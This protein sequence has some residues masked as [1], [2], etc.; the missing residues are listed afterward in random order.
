MTYKIVQ[1][2]N[3]LTET[4]KNSDLHNVSFG[5]SETVIDSVM[6]NGFLKD[7]PIVGTIVGLGKSALSV[8]NLLFL[9]K[10]LYFL[11]EIEDIPSEKRKEMIDF[12]DNNKRHKLK[13]GEKLI[14]IIDKSEDYIDSLYIA[15]FFRAFLEK[16]ITYEEFL[17]GANI[18][19][20]IY[21]G[22]LEYFLETNIS[23]FEKTA[24]TDEN[25]DEETF[26]LIN[27]GICGFG[28]NSINIEDNWDHDISEKYI[29]K[30]GEV[31]IWVT[32]IG[33]KL[34]EI[35]KIVR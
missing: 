11:S 12:I 23:E 27:V 2:E 1:F 13:V 30:G 18:I 6:D 33:K 15:Q 9:K 35:L 7:L 25:P 8:K 20:S 26:P 32:S 21:K 34:K 17:K 22:D 5:L 4:L 28:Y 24:S 29:V 16:E 19:Q 14:F 10:I 3:S 31:V